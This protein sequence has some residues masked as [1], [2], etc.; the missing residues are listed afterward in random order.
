M[1]T[2]KLIPVS[3]AERIAKR[4]KHLEVII[5][6]FGD[7]GKTYVT[8]YGIDKQHCDFAKQGANRITDILGL[9]METI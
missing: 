1:D 6:A 9:Q 5:L 2:T 3:T 8:T 7:D 4:Y